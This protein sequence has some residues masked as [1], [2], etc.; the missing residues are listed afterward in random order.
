MWGELL[1]HQQ[2]LCP[3]IVVSVETFDRLWHVGPIRH[4]RSYES[5]LSEPACSP[6]GVRANIHWG[7]TEFCPNGFGGG[8]VVAEIF[9]DPY[10]VGGG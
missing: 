5:I 7:G 9:R 3:A 2:D 4:E 8:G 10:S 6:I 1:Q